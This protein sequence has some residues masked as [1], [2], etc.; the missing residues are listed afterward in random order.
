MY[1]KARLLGR[2]HKKQKP[3]NKQLLQE[4]IDLPQR[5]C[6]IVFNEGSSPISLGVKHTRFIQI[7]AEMV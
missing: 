4:V 3:P 2:Y 1:G 7:S 6:Q 5:V